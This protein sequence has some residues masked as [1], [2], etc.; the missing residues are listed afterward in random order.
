VLVG[1][2]VGALLGGVLGRNTAAI[3]NGGAIAAV[4]TTWFV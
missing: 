1:Y 4:V 2:L 3:V